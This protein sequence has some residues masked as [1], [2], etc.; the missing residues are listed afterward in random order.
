M[1]YRAISLENDQRRAHFAYFSTMQNPYVGLTAEVEAGAI[2][3]ACASEM[4]GRFRSPWSGVRAERR[5]P[6]RRSGLP[7]LKGEVAFA[8]QM[9]ERLMGG[10]CPPLQGAV[11]VAKK[12][13]ARERG[14]LAMLEQVLLGILA[15]EVHQLRTERILDGLV[16][17]VDGVDIDVRGRDDDDDVL[18]VGVDMQM[19]LGAHELGDVDGGIDAVVG[20]MDMNR[21]DTDDDVGGDVCHGL[22][23]FLLVGG[24]LEILALHGGDVLIALLRERGVE[25]VHLRRADEAGDEEVR[26]MVEDLLRRADLL[27]E[28]VAHDDDAVAERH[29]L[30]LVVRDVD[31]GGVDLLAQLDD[32]SA[33]LV[34]QLGVEVGQRL[35]HQE[36]LRAA[37]DGAA[38]GDT[39]PLAA[40]QGL[41]LTV[42]VLRD[43]EDLGGLFDL[44]VDLRLGDL[45]QL[46]GEGHIIINSHVGIER[47]VLEDHG[48]VAV[49]RG[50]VVHEL[51]V[52][53][54]LALGDLLQTGDH[55]ERCGFAAAGRADEDDEFLVLD[56]EVELLHGDDALLGDLKV[57]LLL[58]D[59]VTLFL[60]L[61]LLFP[62][63]ERV[64][65]FYIDQT[66]FCHT[67]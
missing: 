24:Q 8:K 41:G 46:E 18:A 17:A 10:Q 7:P 6:S 52:D 28:A 57:V 45:L 39:L 34:T 60:L 37:D 32:L 12:Q 42:E 53:V 58:G 48:D 13:P 62:T 35:V 61:F 56:V 51:A 40:G 9:T 20:Q 63:D 38:D 4:A 22:E 65:L 59:F 15:E 5:T 36:D 25:E 1:R 16:A 67:D 55:A 3:G 14:P 29:G 30:D 26:R 2:L 19:Q 33:H 21:T 47:V 66:Y 54:Q 49:L 44:A 31:E 27:D 11:E 64:D 43:V 23:G 50:D